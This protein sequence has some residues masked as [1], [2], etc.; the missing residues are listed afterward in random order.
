[1]TTKILTTG[2]ERPIGDRPALD[3]VP[4][5]PRLPRALQTVLWAARP[6]WFMHHARRRYAD[7]FTIRPYA[8]GDMVVLANPE[9]ITEVFTDARSSSRQDTAPQSASA[10]QPRTDE[11]RPRQHAKRIELREDRYRECLQG[12]CTAG[13]S[14]LGLK[15]TARAPAML[16]SCQERER[17]LRSVNTFGRADIVHELE[18]SGV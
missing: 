18:A 4:P 12:R 2:V 7:V 1:M 8:F 10:T 17:T 16:A 11:V 5:G 3:G 13:L 14:R 6:Q 9:H 15:A